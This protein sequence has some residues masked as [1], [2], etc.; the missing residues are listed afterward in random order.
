MLSALNKM[1]LHG[2]EDELLNTSPYYG[3]FLKKALVKSVVL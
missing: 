2:E 1:C 3:C